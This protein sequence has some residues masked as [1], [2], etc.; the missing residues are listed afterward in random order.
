MENHSKVLE[1]PKGLPPIHFHDHVIHLIR[2]SVPPNIMP[3]RYPYAQKS[4]IERMVAEMQEA[5]VRTPICT[6]L[7][8]ILTSFYFLNHEPQ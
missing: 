4:E 1:T 7:L 5:G 2:E 6:I 3:Y 8:Y